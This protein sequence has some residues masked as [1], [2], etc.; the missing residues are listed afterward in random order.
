[1]KAARAGLVSA[2]FTA[3]APLA[4]AALTGHGAPWLA[5]PIGSMVAFV[6]GTCAERREASTIRRGVI[7]S[8]PQPAADGAVYG[9]APRDEVTVECRWSDEVA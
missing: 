2:P 5:L 9:I 3:F 1:M 8:D 4:A 7:V 6:G